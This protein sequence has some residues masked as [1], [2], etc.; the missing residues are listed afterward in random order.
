M[1]KRS[2]I[3][4]KSR[5][6]LGPTKPPVLWVK[7]KVQFTLEQALKGQKGSIVIALLF[8]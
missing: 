8:L 1:G 3:L 2:F 6:L 4:N 5:L 7:V